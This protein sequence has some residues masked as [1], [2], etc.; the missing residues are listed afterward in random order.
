MSTITETTG[1]VQ[2]ENPERSA[3]VKSGDENLSSSSGT[4]TRFQLP[5]T[6]PFGPS[7]ANLHRDGANVRSTKPSGPSWANLHRDG[8]NVRSIKPSG[9]SWADLLKQ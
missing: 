9:P 2:H 5:S 6:N 7:W 3:A 8:A 4:T 1:P